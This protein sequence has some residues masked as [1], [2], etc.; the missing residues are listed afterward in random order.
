MK[1]AIFALLLSSLNTLAEPP[2][3]LSR[4]IYSLDGSHRELVRLIKRFDLN[5]QSFRHLET[6]VKSMGDYLLITCSYESK[7]RHGNYEVQS[8]T[9]RANLNGRLLIGKGMR[10]G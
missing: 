1:Y 6:K 5:P 3:N 10:H 8:I 2:I 7:L 9:V 4:D